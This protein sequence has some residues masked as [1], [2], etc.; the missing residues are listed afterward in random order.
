MSMNSKN[1]IQSPNLD[2]LTFDEDWCKAVLEKA[3]EEAIKEDREE[4]RGRAHS[5]STGRSSVQDLPAPCQLRQLIS[6]LFYASLET[7]EGV[8]PQISVIWLPSSSTE[9]N[10]LLSS[11]I[12]T[13]RMIRFWEERKRINDEKQL[14]LPSK[15][16]RKLS[17]LCDSEE[18]LLLVE[19]S[20]S[21]DEG[22][23][24]W[25]ILD[26][27]HPLTTEANG[28]G[29]LLELSTYPKALSVHFDHPGSLVVKWGGKYLKD[30][31]GDEEP[32]PIADLQL[33]NT[34]REE[35]RSENIDGIVDFGHESTG[36]RNIEDSPYT[37][38]TLNENAQML[39]V[40]SMM[41]RL[42]NRKMGGTFL[43]TSYESDH[44]ESGDDES[45]REKLREKLH[46]SKE[47]GI[48]ICQHLSVKDNIKKWIDDNQIIKNSTYHIFAD[49]SIRYRLRMVAD[50]LANFATVDGSVI[51]SRNLCL[52]AFAAKTDAP[53]AS[54]IDED[55]SDWLKSH[56]TR[57]GS[58]ANWVDADPCKPC[59]P[60]QGRFALVVSQDGHANAIYWKGGKVHR[61]AIIYRC[62]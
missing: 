55:A 10:R 19:P 14:A 16:L 34:R 62:L 33:F 25:G 31:P 36:H 2:L 44:S 35:Y 18:I 30:F 48:L 8:H 39:V 40:E 27:R 24:A 20:G 56:G 37:W 42:V 12:E 11:L 59:D 9:A 26:L 22:L 60:S 41:G 57:H 38:Q 43:F 47:S 4:V 45:R 46:I 13:N 1:H 5:T 3:K 49:S 6:I 32:V 21:R 51:L 29:D 61:S 17:A 15:E 7:E 53:D 50:W 54:N 58:A 28:P 52:L 23:I